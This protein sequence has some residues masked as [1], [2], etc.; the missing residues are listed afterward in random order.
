M[1][2]KRQFSRLLVAFVLVGVSCVAHAAPRA[3][4]VFIVSFDG[5]NPDEMKKSA[6]PT[7][8]EMA[9]QGAQ[10]LKA[11]TIFPSL[12]LP[13][14]TSMLTGVG[15]DKHQILWNGWEPKRGLVKV[16]TVF[17]VARDTGYTTAMF[18]G[19]IKFRHLNLPGSLDEV[20]IPAYEAQTVAD[21]AAK[22]IVEQKPNLCF[23]HFADSD[24]A[25]HGFGWGSPQQIKAFGDE[26]IAL[27]TLRDAVEKAGIAGSSVLILSADHGGHGKGHGSA[28]PVDMTIP[29]VAWGANVKPK[30]EISDKV[31]TYDTAA[32]ALWL[33]EVPIPANF[34]GKPVE[35][36]FVEQK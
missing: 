33:L 32:T 2:I 12:T 16:P 6:M 28:Q 7:F 36:A 8:F 30:F 19:K 9:A 21:A 29:W 23:I 35:S 31:T 3:E 34:D 10:T 24:G 26:D 27:K 18:A 13:S 25:G 11:Q 22:Y 4:H 1:N 15:P 17:S 14:H 5:G 20:Q